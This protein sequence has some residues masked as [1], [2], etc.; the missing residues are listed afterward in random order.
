MF[1]LVFGTSSAVAR[2]RQRCLYVMPRT[3]EDACTQ[4]LN[5]VLV[6]QWSLSAIVGGWLSWSCKNV[7]RTSAIPPFMAVPYD[8]KIATAFPRSMMC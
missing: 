8:N 1:L 2:P 5:C 3:Q 6:L 4:H 7:M